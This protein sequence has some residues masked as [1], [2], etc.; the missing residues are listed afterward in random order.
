MW[1]VEALALANRRAE[2]EEVF[3][4]LLRRAND[5]GL[6]SEEVD[7]DT[8]E[9]L[10]NFP[11]ALTH[12]GLM[13]AALCLSAEDRTSPESARTSRAQRAARAEWPARS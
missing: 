6:F 11:Q 5:V 9:L 1:L 8:G 2:A 4:K 7:P 13:N 12:I 3:E 10:G